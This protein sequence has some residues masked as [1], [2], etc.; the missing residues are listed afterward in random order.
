MCSAQNR[1][2]KMCQINHNEMEAIFNAV[3][4]AAYIFICYFFCIPFTPFINKYELLLLHPGN[5]IMFTVNY[6]DLAN[7][8]I[9]CHVYSISRVNFPF[10]SDL[11]GSRTKKQPLHYTLWRPASYLWLKNSSPSSMH[12]SD[13]DSIT[14]SEI[15]F[16][17]F[18]DVVFLLLF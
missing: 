5:I 12:C 18:H 2:E 16:S 3:L 4:L 13:F 15:V 17:F 7:P 8:A 1:V 9:L 10:E 14:K 11:S 6:T